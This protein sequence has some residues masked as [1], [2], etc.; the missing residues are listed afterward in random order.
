[1]SDDQP[2]FDELVTYLNRVLPGAESYTEIEELPDGTHTVSM[3]HTFTYEKVYGESMNIIVGNGD[4][5][6]PLD[7][8]EGIGYVEGNDGRRYYGP[9]DGVPPPLDS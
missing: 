5:S 8:D 9:Q 7:P 3:V 4:G 1:M 2:R 6:L